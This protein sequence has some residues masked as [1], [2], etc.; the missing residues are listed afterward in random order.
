M[1]GAQPFFVSGDVDGFFGLAIDNLIQFILV[2]ALSSAVLGMSVDHILG[3]VIPGAAVSVL[4]GNL[5]YA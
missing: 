4:V 1:R 3:T 5:F 2:L